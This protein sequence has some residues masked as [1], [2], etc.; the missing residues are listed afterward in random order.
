M[1]AGADWVRA[2][3][4]T[5]QPVWGLRGGLQ[6]AIHP[7]GFRGATGGP[8]G[9]IRLGY[10]VLSNGVY[11]LV[12]FIAVEP[13]VHG[14]KGYSELENSRLDHARGK[15][16]W[17]ATKGASGRDG[18]ELEPGTLTQPALGVQRLEVP[19]HI[20]SFD[21]GAHVSLVVSQR[22][23]APDEIEITIRTE[24]GSAPIEH[25]VLTAT[26][27]NMARTRLLWLKNEVASS[28]ALYPDYK[29]SGFAPHTSFGLE[30][31]HVTVA[32]DVL[33]ALTTDEAAPAAVFPFPG[34]RLW[35][36]GGVKVT[37]YWRKPKGG[38]RDDLH[39]VVNAR[40]VYWQSQ[41]PIPGGIAFEN[42]ELR[43]RFYDGQRF[44]FGITTNSPL[45]MGFKPAR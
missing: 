19:I 16:F 3:L 29:D 8:R 44:V 38:Y 37:Q 25:C 6:F 21:N 17:V 10:G 30:R 31:L 32:G 5:N 18:L 26:M 14:A 23:D 33:V 36:Y 15:R 22:S 34:S 13:T 45:Q 4:N 27:G 7:G 41:R 20:E 24:S 11:D 12:N 35:H 39:A 42:F 28:L 40:H 9:L 2:G 43:E 1:G